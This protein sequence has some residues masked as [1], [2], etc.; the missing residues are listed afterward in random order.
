MVNLLRRRKVRTGYGKQLGKLS[1]AFASAGVTTSWM[2]S[3]VAEMTES[4]WD[5]YVLEARLTD[6][7]V[8]TLLHTVGLNH[9][10]AVN[11]TNLAPTITDIQAVNWALAYKKPGYLFFRIDARPAV[12][13]DYFNSTHR[14]AIASN[15]AAI[16]TM[17]ATLE[18]SEGIRFGLLL[19]LE[20]YLFSSNPTQD[21]FKYPSLANP[22]ARTFSQ[23][24]DDV[25]L[26]F[27]D[28]LSAFWTNH[29]TGNVVVTLGA[30]YAETVNFETTND[31]ATCR[32]GLLPDAI[33][34]MLDAIDTFPSA[35]LSDYIQSGYNGVTRNSHEY[36]R[37]H[38]TEGYEQ[39]T[40][41]LRATNK[42]R[43]KY[44]RAVWPNSDGRRM[45]T[46]TVTA[47]NT[48]TFRNN[49]HYFSVNDV[50]YIE[51]IG[52]RTVTATGAGTITVN[53]AAFNLATDKYVSSVLPNQAYDQIKFGSQAADRFIFV[54]MGG[55]VKDGTDVSATTRIRYPAE[56]LNSFTLANRNRLYTAL[57][58]VPPVWVG[59]ISPITDLGDFISSATPV[60]DMPFNEASGNFLDG[61]GAA[62]DFS[63]NGTVPRNGTS[64]E[65]Y[66][67]FDSN[68]ANHLSRASDPDLDPGSGDFLISAR[69]RVANAATSNG[70]LGKASAWL[71]RTNGATTGAW[72]IPYKSA[73]AQVAQVSSVI[74]SNTWHVVQAWINGLNAKIR[75]D[76]GTE[77]TKVM[78]SG[79][80]DTNTNVIKI[81]VS[82]T[83]SCLGDI[84]D[85]VIFKHALTS[86]E[87]NRLLAWQ[88]LKSISQ[89]QTLFD[90]QWAT[91][92]A[93]A[94]SEA[95]SGDSFRM[96]NQSYKLDGLVCM[97]Q[98]TGNLSY[99]DDALELVGEWRGSAAI[100]SNLTITHGAE[101]ND[102]SQYQD[103]YLGW[104]GWG[105][106]RTG[107]EYPLDESYFAKY[108]IRLLRIM[109]EANLHNHPDYSA[110][111]A[112][113]LAFLEANMWGKWYARGNDS[114]GNGTLFRGPVSGVHMTCQ[115][116]QFALH[117][118]KTSANSTILTQTANFLTEI[119]DNTNVTPAALNSSNLRLEMRNHTVHGASAYE[120]DQTW[121]GGAIADW[122][123]AN[124]VVSFIVEEFETNAGAGEWL[125][126]D[127]DK[128]Q[129]LFNAYTPGA[130]PVNVDGSGGLTASFVTSGFSR[131][132]RFSYATQQK[133]E[134]FTGNTDSLCG[135]Y[136]NNAYNVRRL[137]TA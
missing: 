55:D 49:E 19:D 97:Y 77:G 118:N 33:D 28:A 3:N 69:F 34:G 60:L 86:A 99:I 106:S 124:D 100:S 21:I 35:R 22:S 136:G 90:A 14:S 101:G 20:T 47:G 57:P 68:S 91:E 92:K 39:N 75:V 58:A 43:L 74:S 87:R 134:N 131:L 107:F 96:L 98:A 117:M 81:G 116:A 56:I 53:G 128:F 24:R 45:T 95:Q 120:F 73:A 104:Q 127:I 51:G 66:A 10:T 61:S 16:G 5:G 50:V 102:I 9:L 135:M 85:V 25:R 30:L 125:Q 130:Y 17:C 88:G 29:P 1:V 62:N 27:D 84:E 114:Q 137:L 15:F 83:N 111:Y 79:S 82:D 54:Y 38:P 32:F 41:R 63:R 46:G 113:N 2:V 94:I 7:T 4:Y 121:G 105:A 8:G 119:N 31:W 18:A 76:G 115:W 36:Y 67:S 108:W 109:K 112:T 71:L 72:F 78:P 40:T 122:N 93:G 26:F 48:I 52:N 59:G 12:N 37:T 13:M 123:H 23:T 11:S 44:D 70:L 64:P 89:W 132:G 129:F 133:L 6:T 42:S 65:F 103:S 126:A 110:L 80:V